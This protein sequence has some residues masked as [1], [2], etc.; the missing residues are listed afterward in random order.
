M[1]AKFR[2][3]AQAPSPKDLKRWLTLDLL[4]WVMEIVVKATPQRRSEA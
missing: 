1:G 4:G 3:T 2:T